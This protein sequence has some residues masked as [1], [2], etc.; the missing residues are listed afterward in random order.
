MCPKKVTDSKDVGEGA[1]HHAK[2][3]GSLSH[4]KITGRFVTGNSEQGRRLKYLDRQ[5]TVW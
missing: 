3:Q 4:L 1:E 5:K 2:G